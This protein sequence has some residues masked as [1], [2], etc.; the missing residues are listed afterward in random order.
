M[1]NFRCPCGCGC[2]VYTP[3]P[4]N[5]VCGLCCRGSHAMLW[6]GVSVSA[7]IPTDVSELRQVAFTN[8]SVTFNAFIDGN[9]T[10]DGG[11]G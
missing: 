3:N 10:G 5:P 7:D 6:D 11:Q 2:G 1:G 9:V 8:E 4:P